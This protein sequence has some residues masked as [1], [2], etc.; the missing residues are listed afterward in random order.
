MR[1]EG[2]TI[3]SNQQ[4]FPFRFLISFSRKIVR[5]EKAGINKK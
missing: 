3:N 5:R 2:P 1:N 4:P